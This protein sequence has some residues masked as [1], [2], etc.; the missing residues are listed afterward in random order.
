MRKY[1]IS[2][3]EIDSRNWE[4]ERDREWEKGE[5]ENARASDRKFGTQLYEKEKHNTLKFFK[6]FLKKRLFFV[7]GERVTLE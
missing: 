1:G 4:S 7:S 3:I 2:F 6:S 5:R